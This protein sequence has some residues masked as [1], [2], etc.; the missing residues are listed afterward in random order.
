MTLNTS[1]DGPTTLDG[2]VA[3]KRALSGHA[4]YASLDSV[5]RLRVFMQHH[6]VCVLDFMS[7]VKSLQRDLT[8]MGSVWVPPTDPE[9]ARFINEIVL[10]EESDAEFTRYGGHGPASHFEWYL[11]AM[12]QLGADTL[13][14][15]ALVAAVRAGEPIQDALAES[16]LPA[17]ARAFGQTTF[18]LLE[19]PLHVRASVFF[20][21]REDVIPKMFLPIVERL[22]SEGVACDLLLGYLQR[23]IEADGEHHGPLA[24]RLLRATFANDPAREAAGVRAAEQALDAREA[25]WNATLAAMAHE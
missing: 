4:L 16:T 2:L 1:H 18:G 19:G 13:P 5:E 17:A 10:D 23:H 6:V 14:I 9:V 24:A 20:H 8:S 21:G 11:A 7:I 25:L 15:E 12:R 22:Q 3:R